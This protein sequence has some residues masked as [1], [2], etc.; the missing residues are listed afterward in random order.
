[1]QVL[2]PLAGGYLP[3]SDFAMR[4]SGIVALLNDIV[5]HR[6]SRVVELGGGI[7]TLYLGR[8]LRR[9]G[10]HLYTLEHDEAWVDLLGQL[11]AAEGLHGVV[12]VVHAPLAATAHGWAAGARWYAED[13][14]DKVRADGPIELLVVDGPTAWHRDLRHA[15]YPA[16]PFF[17]EALARGATVVLDDIGRRGEQDVVARWER[18]LGVPF[19][20][21]FDDGSIAVGRTART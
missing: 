2:A 8:L 17:W 6:R 5:L 18:E 16:L 3:W 21:R 19:E 15:R 11:L 12:T 10:G 14:A 7:S 13:P 9:R 4:P 1:M 20:R